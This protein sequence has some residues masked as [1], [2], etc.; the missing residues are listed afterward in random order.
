M[1][2]WNN[3]INVLDAGIAIT[4]DPSRWDLSNPEY[5]KIYAQWEQANFNMSAIKWTNFYPGQQFDERLVNTISQ[6]LGI[7]THRAWISKIEP[8]YFAPWHWDVDDNINEYKSKGDIQ[9]YSIFVSNPHP[10]HFF[11]TD[12]QVFS[13]TP[14]GTVYKWKDSNSWHAGANAGLTPKYMFHILG[15]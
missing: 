13:N 1:I 4:P 15:Y 14:Q 3:V 8:G 7:T 5:Q 10:A 11:T 6:D 2:E 12:D 9:R